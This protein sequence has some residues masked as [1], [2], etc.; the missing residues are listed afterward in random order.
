MTHSPRN[1]FLFGAA[2]GAVIALVTLTLTIGRTSLEAL[3]SSDGTAALE[4]TTGALYLVVLIAGSLGGL[5][6]GAIGYA[7][8][9][10]DDSETPR[11]PLRYLLPVAAVTAAL[12]SYAVLRIGIGAF[13]DIGGGVASIGALR[14]TITVLAMGGVAG[15]V[16]AAVVDGLARPELFAFEGEAWPRSGREVMSAMMSAVGAPLTAAVAAA[17]FTIPLSM[18]LIELSGDAAV[19]FFSVVGALV[20]GAA[21][22]IAARPW[23]KPEA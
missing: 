18:V 4:V 12:V 23:D 5:L 22:I 20:L 19:I 21:A 16:T 7:T 3:T 11:F 1:A 13:G 8:G 9:L 10:P 14:L 2:G 6:I 15:G 17:V